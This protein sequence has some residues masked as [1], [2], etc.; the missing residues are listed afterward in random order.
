MMSTFHIL[1]IWERSF[2]IYYC[3]PLITA[4]SRMLEHY[5]RREGIETETPP[6]V[7]VSPAM[8]VR[9]GAVPKT[10]ET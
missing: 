6:K 10:G 2:F 5:M 8:A 3:S 4:G 9:L 1:F 7:A